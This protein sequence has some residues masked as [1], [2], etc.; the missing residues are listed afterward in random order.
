MASYLLTRM[1]MQGRLVMKQADMALHVVDLERYP[2]AD[3]S[4]GDGSA[5]LASCQ[6]QMET[7]GWS[8][9]FVPKH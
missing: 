9:S 7:H 5:F 6:E 2:I 4:Q 8:G 3:L 1:D